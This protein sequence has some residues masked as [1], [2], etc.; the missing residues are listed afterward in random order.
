MIDVAATMQIA[1]CSADSSVVSRSR[2]SGPNVVARKIVSER[3]RRG[4]EQ[5]RVLEQLAAEDR[6]LLVGRLEREEDVEE[7]ERHE[8]HRVGDGLAVGILGPD[9][10]PQRHGRRRPARRRPATAISGPRQ[11]LRVLGPGRLLHQARARLAVAEADGL[12]DGHREV[13][14]QGLERQERDAAQDV[15][16]ARARGTWR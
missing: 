1:H 13:D 3:Q 9:D 14:P 2:W 8:A 6:P 12:E 11:D 4:L 7:R 5:R 16:D 10:Q 15:E